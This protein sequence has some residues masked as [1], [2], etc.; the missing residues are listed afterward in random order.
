MSSSSL[1]AAAN[2]ASI[3]FAVAAACVVATADSPKL[4]DSTKKS[5]KPTSP[6]PVSPS[7]DDATVTSAPHVALDTSD[8]VARLDIRDP[9]LQLNFERL[10]S[11]RVPRRRA[12]PETETSALFSRYSVISFYV[13]GGGT[14]Q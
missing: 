2:A 6:S 4:R 1:S 10:L 9:L 8:Y 12:E 11:K 14:C 13:R 3:S 7:R 5:L